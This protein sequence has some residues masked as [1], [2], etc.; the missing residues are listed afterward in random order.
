MTKWENW[1]KSHI[2]AI[3]GAEKGRKKYD[4]AK[5][6]L[7]AAN[8]DPGYLVGIHK[9]ADMERVREILGDDEEWGVTRHLMSTILCENADPDDREVIVEYN[10]KKRRYSEN[11]NNISTDLFKV[12]FQRFY[13]YLEETNVEITDL[14]NLPSDLKVEEFR[15]LVKSRQHLVIYVISEFETCFT[16]LALGDY[17]MERKLETECDEYWTVI[18]ELM[19]ELQAFNQING[20]LEKGLNKEVTDRWFR[21]VRNHKWSDERV[22][23][24]LLDMVRKTTDECEKSDSRYDV[25]GYG[26]EYVLYGAIEALECFP[27][28]ESVSL[29]LDSLLRLKGNNF[30]SSSLARLIHISHAPLR[31]VLDESLGQSGKIGATVRGEPGW[32]SKTQENIDKVAGVIGD[33]Y[34]HKAPS[35]EVSI[36][37]RSLFGDTALWCN[38]REFRRL[39]EHASTSIFTGTNADELVKAVASRI[40]GA[41]IESDTDDCLEVIR[42]SEVDP[43]F[44]IRAL[45]RI[46]GSEPRRYIDVLSYDLGK[47]IDS[48]IQACIEPCNA[49]LHDEDDVSDWMRPAPE[50]K[51]CLGNPPELEENLA[52][53]VKT[54]EKNDHFKSE[55]SNRIYK[56][57]LRNYLGSPESKLVVLEAIHRSKKKIS[58]IKD[59]IISDLENWNTQCRIVKF[60]LAKASEHYLGEIEVSSAL[61]SIL[62]SEMKRKADRQLTVQIGKV[63]AETRHKDDLEELDIIIGKANK[64]EALI[65]S[66]VLAENYAWGLSEN[67]EKAL[68][69][70]L[71]MN[72]LTTCEILRILSYKDCSEETLSAA[73]QLIEKPPGNGKGEVHGYIKCCALRV[74]AR[75]RHENPYPKLIS[76]FI[77]GDMVKEIGKPIQEINAAR[78]STLRV[79]FSA[80]Y[81]VQ[82]S[83]ATPANFTHSLM[84]SLSSHAKEELL[85]NVD[86]ENHLV[87]YGCAATL[88]RYYTNL[89]DHEKVRPVIMEILRKG[90]LSEYGLRTD[91]G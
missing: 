40:L 35:E 65:W 29:V 86:D 55:Y 79:S 30:A 42:D 16:S 11:A 85:E 84:F 44:L 83:I 9:F 53:L 21:V 3:M 59:H 15:E 32:D 18:P 56:N 91:E 69:W 68:S 28:D 73:N 14:L 89:G 80:S 27:D 41:V 87:R 67:V 78:E 66:M 71:E 7:S 19:G 47:G 82:G 39:V 33:I 58:A 23:D 31:S 57:L 90:L 25:G 38:D 5:R 52:E 10:L 81:T 74:I 62:K 45:E 60:S 6:V 49:N 72:S 4:I 36:Q 77:L 1:Q 46:G 48:L 8:E 70:G 61:I 12:P 26:K 22:R 51:S 75:T 64:K 17:D 54:L 20:L 34:M 88:A 63:I 13:K 43:G 24:Q 76:M 2:G 50:L 37:V